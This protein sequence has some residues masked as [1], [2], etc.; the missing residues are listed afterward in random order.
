MTGD[1]ELLVVWSNGSDI[2]K[3]GGKV[4]IIILY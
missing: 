4:G 3:L 2:A 1:E